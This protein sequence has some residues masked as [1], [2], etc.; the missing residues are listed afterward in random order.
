MKKNAKSYLRRST[1]SDIVPSVKTSTKNDRKI[2]WSCGWY[3]KENKLIE[4]K[5]NLFDK[6]FATLVSASF[7]SVI[8]A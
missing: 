1:H 2:E 8:F 6:F 5:E 3:R 7:F 4:K